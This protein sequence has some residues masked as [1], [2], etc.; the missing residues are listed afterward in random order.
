MSYDDIMGPETETEQD[1]SLG[2]DSPRHP[3]TCCCSGCD[4]G[5]SPLT[6]SDSSEG[7]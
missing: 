6:Y 7:E 4:I 2:D 5:R 1:W 3:E